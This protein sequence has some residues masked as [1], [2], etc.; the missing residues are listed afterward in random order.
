MRILFFAEEAGFGS[1]FSIIDILE[2]FKHEEGGNVGRDLRFNAGARSVQ[3]ECRTT[4]VHEIELDVA[5]A[6]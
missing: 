3:A 2:W 1:C 5:T 6:P 4:V